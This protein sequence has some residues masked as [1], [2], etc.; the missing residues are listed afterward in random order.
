[1]EIPRQPKTTEKPL[2]FEKNHQSATFVGDVQIKLKRGEP[3]DRAHVAWAK[4]IGL[5]AEAGDTP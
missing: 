3:R 5:I 2:K 1:M 4:R